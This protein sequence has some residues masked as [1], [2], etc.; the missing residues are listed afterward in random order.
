[1]RLT[2]R[3]QH[4]LFLIFL[5]LLHAIS[6]AAQ[7]S[8]E[9][10]LALVYGDKSSISIATG[11]QQPIVRAPAAA[12]VIT[13]QDIQAMGATDLDQALESVPG[14]HVSFA[15]L[16]SHPIYSFRGIFTGYN[17]QVLMLVNGMPITNVFA[18]DRGL[19]WGGMPLENV[20]RIEVIR[21]PGSALY[22]ADAYAGVINIITKTAEDINGTEYG[23]RLGT[24]RTRDAWV[25]HGGKLGVLDAAF[26]LRAGH[27]DG[28]DG[29]IQQDLQSSLDKNFGTNAS[30]APGSINAFRNAVDARADLAYGKWRFR[31]AYQDRDVGI[32]G[33]L[34]ENLDPYSSVPESRLY[35]DL[36]Y[37]DANWA[38]NWDVSAILGYYDIREKP[39]DPPFLLFPPGAFKGKFPDGVIG[40]P[41]HSERHSSASISAFY[42]GF[43]YH[44][45]RFGTGFRVEDLYE[46]TETKNFNIIAG[47][48]FVPLTGGVE[49]VSNDPSLVYM[50]PHKRHLTYLFGQDEW[51]L[52]N[53]WTLTA[54]VRQDDY[55]DF[56]STTNPRLA[57]VWNAAYN[58]VIKAM[59]GRAFRAPNFTELYSINNPVATGNPNLRPETITTDELA[60]SWQPTTDLQTNLSLFRYRM[61]DIIRFVPNADPTTGSTAQNTGTQTGRGAEIELTWDATR[62][63]RLTGNLSL[64]RSIDETTGEDAGLAPHKHLF[65]R[66]DWRFAPLWQFGSIVNYV[67]DRKREPGD[68]RP[69]IP[70][71]TTV[72]LTLRR[73]KLV[74]DWDVRATV[75][76]L[77][78]RDA[79]EPSL[80]PGNIPFDLPLPGRAFYIQF[81]HSL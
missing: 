17:P 21:G 71:Y 34:A 3:L 28:Q 62:S 1:M 55:S 75:L 10:D 79:R 29:V 24:F 78:D 33:G 30:F 43:D 53:D 51:S 70:D 42:T 40:D 68:T 58:V 9:E 56:G 69:P 27:T 25:Q 36:T 39:S 74:D 18:G 2:K 50:Q 11:S 45:L 14:L 13:A 46:A 61:N 81:Q 60:F 8:D 20:E 6:M 54:G 57:L 77:F 44:K 67:A 52:A 48:T 66:A 59:H 19:G 37:R 15:S 23:V 49:D 38:P 7:I 72:D 35:M 26:Y 4:P 5:T 16:A 76:N 65:A 41:A 63:L 64:Q 31:T 80:A 22:G 73:E 47:P 32:G 12:T